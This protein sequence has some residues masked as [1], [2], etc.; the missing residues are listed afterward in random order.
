[1]SQTIEIEL[2]NLLTKDEFDKVKRHFS[3]TD[4]DFKR[5]E[6]FYFDTKQRTLA[7]NHCALRIR[8]KEEDRY[9]ITLK[10]PHEHGLL[11]TNTPLN[12]EEAEALIRKNIFPQRA[13][14]I[15][16]I[17][18]SLSI[19]PN[20]LKLFGQLVTYRAVVRYANGLLAVDY[21]CYAGTEDYELEFEVADKQEGA[22]V[23]HHLLQT[24]D[25]P[26]RQTEN[27]IK[28]F[29]GQMS[30]SGGKQNET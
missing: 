21:S 28:R 29:F 8:K 15:Q 3:L 20:D 26:V 13:T 2:K 25:I 4:A 10:Q 7:S 16:T 14:Q 30:S 1:V 23:F 18:S 17:L 19:H 24:L 22:F 12:S 5:Q 27:K 11:E 6:N 9:E